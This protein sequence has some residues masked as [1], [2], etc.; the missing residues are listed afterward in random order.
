[1]RRILATLL[2]L[3]WLAG[4]TAGAATLNSTVQR[5][6]AGTYWS[7]TWKNLDPSCNAQALS[8]AGLGSWALTID[9]TSRPGVR[10]GVSHSNSGEGEYAV[11]APNG[12]LTDITLNGQHSFTCGTDTLTLPGFVA[13]GVPAQ[14]ASIPTLSEWSLALTSAVLGL[15][16]FG[17][18]RRRT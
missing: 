9:G 5:S 3:S 8:T 4:S 10:F 14:P 13:P 15:A 2:A 17:W 7:I 11:N 12:T 6:P 16:G 18:L 1:M